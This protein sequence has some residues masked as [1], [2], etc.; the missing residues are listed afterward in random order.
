MKMFF[1]LYLVTNLGQSRGLLCCDVSPDGLTVAAG[2]E[3]LGDDA[4]ILYWYASSI[5]IIWSIPMGF[6]PSSLP[7]MPM[8]QS[9]A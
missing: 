3:L 9:S 7:T 5:F 8:G 2:T 6:V 1:P 4:L